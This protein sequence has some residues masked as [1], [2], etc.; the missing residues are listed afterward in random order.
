LETKSYTFPS[1]ATLEKLLKDA[2]FV[3]N[4]VRAASLPALHLVLPD[5]HGRDLVRA[6]MPEVF[7][8]PLLAVLVILEGSWMQERFA[9]FEKRIKR[10]SERH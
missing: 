9:G 5:V 7:R 4:H 6:K 8:Q 1:A 2:G 3:I 10:L